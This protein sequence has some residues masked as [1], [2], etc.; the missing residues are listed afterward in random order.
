[1]SITQYREG[2][3]RELLKIAIPLMIS[4]LSMVGMLFADRVFLSWYHPAAINAAASAG[5]LAWAIVFGCQL[6]CSIAEVFVAQRNG[7]KNR[8]LGAPVWQ[9]IWL[10][11]FLPIIVVP[12]ALWGTPLIYPEGSFESDYF[13]WML[14]S[15]QGFALM[16]ALIAF[17]IGQ[18]KTR[19]VM[20]MAILGNTVNTVLDP[21][22]IFGIDGYIPSIGVKGAAIATGLGAWIQALILFCYFIKKS[23]R[24]TFGTGNWHFDK[25]LFKRCLKV[26]L[27]PST[28]VMIELISWGV[29]YTM[30][31]QVSF[32]HIFVAGVCQSILMLFIFFGLGLERASTAICGNHIGAGKRH[33]LPHTFKA[34]VKLTSAFLALLIAV[35]F[36]CP[37][38]L[39]DIFFTNPEVLLEGKALGLS[40][41]NQLKAT[42]HSC[43][44]CVGIYLFFEAIRWHLNGIL[45]AATDTLFLML[46]G[47]TSL[48][49]FMLLPTYYL[50]VKDHGSVTLSLWIWVFYSLCAF[51]V[52]YAR[53]RQEKWRSIRSCDS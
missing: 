51:L 27:P 9:M 37:N 4:N 47:I 26:G 25:S 6:L 2:S 8:N 30:L 34:G 33:L 29:F 40:G 23:N 53:F 24:K 32:E 21:I 5:M 35:Y 15:G 14:Y 10:A 41:I 49:L 44:L 19:L 45:T 52:M 42:I 18:G 22:L 12:I 17:F 36:L 20:V 39:V 48:W 50:I 1:M 38:W 28:Y 7:A 31:A 11:I 43:L 13:R 46:S 3:F 16:G